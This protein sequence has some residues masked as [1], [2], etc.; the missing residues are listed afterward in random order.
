MHLILLLFALFASVFTIGKAALETTEPFFFVGIRMMAAGIIL[1][2]FQGS[3]GFKNIS[4]KRK[5][6][7]PILGLS[8]FNIYLTN[9]LEFWGLC[10][11]TSFKTCFIYSLSPFISALISYFVFS[12]IMTPKKWLG[13]LIGCVGFI[14]ILY[15]QDSTETTQEWIFIAELAVAGACVFN[16]Y[17]W[18]LLKQTIKEN[19][20]S[21]LTAN[22]Y[23]M[24]IGGFFSLLHSFFV[25]NW[26]P[27]PTTDLFAFITS[28]L[29]L[30]LISN[31][32]C[33]N[34]YGYLLKK[35]TATFISFAGFTTPLFAAFYGWLFLNEKIPPAFYLSGIIVFLGL[36]I[37]N[38]EELKVSPVHNKQI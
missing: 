8:L 31:L 30:I 11:L 38:L 20:L 15:Y 1:I 13:L 9:M 18:V 17:G 19:N 21:P 34:L 27:I 25:E 24:L 12:E 23:S 22:G 35:F 4:L 3:K 29:A 2:I 6:F 14:P 7:L 28:T 32:F 16:A 37:F 36:Y 10:R 33:Y 5:D 26:S